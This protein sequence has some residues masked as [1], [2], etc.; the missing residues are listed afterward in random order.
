MQC[1]KLEVQYFRTM[2]QFS[3]RHKA[4][5][6]GFDV[7]LFEIEELLSLPQ[8]PEA[9]NYIRFIVNTYMATSIQYMHD[10]S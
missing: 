9:V 2:K 4:L 10:F 7:V 5:K 8:R 6:P 3:P 1:L